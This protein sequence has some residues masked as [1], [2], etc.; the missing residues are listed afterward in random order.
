[1]SQ[2]LIAQLQAI[3]GPAFVLTRPG[4]LLCYTSDGSIAEA[5]SLPLA[6]VLPASTDEIAAVLQLASASRTP[7]V[8][9]GAGSGLAGGAVASAGA[10]VLALTRLNRIQELNP[11]GMFARVEAGVITGELQA[12]AEALGLCYPPD[13]SSLTVSTIGGN[14]ACNAGGPRCIKYGVT[15][16]YVLGLTAVLAD[17]AVLCLGGQLSRQSPDAGLI[18]LLVGS[19]GTLAVITEAVLRLVPGPAAR[20]TALAVFAQVE[21][22][23]TCV[24]QI[25][26]SGI[27]PAGL[28]LMDDTTINTV[29]DYLALGLPRDAGAL[30]LMLADGAPEAVADE[31]EAMAALAR[32]C[33][34][35]RVEV[36]RDEAQEA[37]LWR[38]RRSVSPS[39]ARLRPNKLG[40]DICVPVPRVAATVRAI[41]QISQQHGLPIPVF[42]HAGDGNLHP[43]ILFDRRNPAE[44]AR[45]WPAA[46][47]IFRLALNMG[48]TLSGE[49]G[50]G[51]LKRAFIAEALGQDVVAASLAVKHAFDPLGI[52]NP[53]KVFEDLPASTARQ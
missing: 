18:Q 52:L 14:I 34:A 51:T 3:V 9:R 31:A 15:A 8:S 13:P 45:V 4:D 28:E 16:D 46:E 11:G 22:A 35:S 32:A 39:L 23:C 21:D 7:V 43:N 38:A 33:G 12:Q 25:M 26:A 19:E 20:R 30:L 2:R 6:V 50:I 37:A 29:E 24:E 49:H 1:M 53:G 10:L 48:G 40:E 36:A 47:A 41:K 27:L 17:G 44:Y 5:A 42:G